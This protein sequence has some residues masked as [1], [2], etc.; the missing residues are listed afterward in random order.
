M[1]EIKKWLNQQLLH[2]ESLKKLG[3][4]NQHD[5]TAWAAYESTLAKILELE[6][7]PPVS[8]NKPA[9]RGNLPP[10]EEQWTDFWNSYNLNRKIETEKKYNPPTLK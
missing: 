9:Y 7:N 10:T 5:R 8:E 2:F 6:W 4:L 1:D 3:Q